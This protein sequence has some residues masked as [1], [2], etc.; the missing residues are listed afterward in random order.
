LQRAFSTHGQGADL[1]SQLSVSI[2]DVPLVTV[3][4]GTVILMPVR[5]HRLGVVGARCL[6]P[7]PLWLVSGRTVAA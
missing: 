3:V 4:N 6:A 1:V 2:R 7:L 5:F